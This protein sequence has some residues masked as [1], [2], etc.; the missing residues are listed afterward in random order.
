MT[1]QLLYILRLVTKI[2][3]KY[4]ILYVF[5]DILKKHINQSELRL[6]QCN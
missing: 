2:T 3:F 6:L 4:V 1:C 5:S